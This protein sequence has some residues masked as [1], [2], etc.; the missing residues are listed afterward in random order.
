M[1]HNGWFNFSCS[2]P[3]L[4]P[5]PAFWLKP[6]PCFRCHT[7]GC[8]LHTQDLDL[9][10]WGAPVL[11]AYPLR[12][13][14]RQALPLPELSTVVSCLPEPAPVYCLGSLLSSV[15]LLKTCPHRQPSKSAMLRERSL[16]QKST[17]CEIPLIRGSRTG[18]TRP[19]W[20]KI[21]TAVVSGG[22]VGRDRSGARRD[23]PG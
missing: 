10:L 18:T 23:L 8:L 20:R 15:R 1:V 6:L 5:S 21:R 3:C 11:Q 12:H 4:A 19:W 13:T 9:P 14:P 2:P 7:I 22:G 16:I 17:F